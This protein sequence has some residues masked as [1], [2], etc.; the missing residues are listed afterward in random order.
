[1]KA[2]VDWTVLLKRIF[3]KLVF[4]LLLVPSAVNWYV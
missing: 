1:M 2:L 4:I 3:G